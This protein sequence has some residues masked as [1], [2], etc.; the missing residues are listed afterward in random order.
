MNRIT[1]TVCGSREE[2]VRQAQ[3]RMASVAQDGATGAQGALVGI[4]LDHDRAGLCLRLVR[5][6]EMDLGQGWAWRPHR[7]FP[8]DR[9]ADEGVEWLLSELTIRDAA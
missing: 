2:F 5:Q 7:A 6:Q 1:E 3:Q 9:A 8:L 4:W